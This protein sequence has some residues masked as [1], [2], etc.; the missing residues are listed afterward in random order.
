MLRYR[1][2]RRCPGVWRQGRADDR[3]KRLGGVQRGGHRGGFLSHLLEAVSEQKDGGEDQDATEGSPRPRLRVLAA[4]GIA[5]V[6][7]A[8]A[9]AALAPFAGGRSRPGRADSRYVVRGHQRVSPGNPISREPGV[10]QRHRRRERQ[11]PD[12]HRAAQV[13]RLPRPGGVRRPRGRRAAFGAPI[14]PRSSS[15]RAL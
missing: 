7:A 13:L 12:G 14:P 9:L 8:L 3:G 4:A 10:R 11:I 15:R 5:V 2:F 6:A 1:S